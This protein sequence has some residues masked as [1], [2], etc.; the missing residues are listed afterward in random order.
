MFFE[1]VYRYDESRR[2]FD[3]R[4]LAPRMPATI[5]EIQTARDG[6]LEYIRQYP[7][8]SSIVPGSS[9]SLITPYDVQSP[10]ITVDRLVA[11]VNE[12]EAGNFRGLSWL[13]A[14]YRHWIRKDRLLRVDAITGERNGTGV[15][16]GYSPVGASKQQME[17]MAALT[18]GYRSGEYSGGSLPPG[19]DLKFKG[20]EGS[21]SEVYREPLSL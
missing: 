14:L 18:Q 2:G 12:Q 4:K 13:R 11:Y 6:G 8:G 16:I 17:Q 3:L 7:S 9:R 1:Q 5:S 19:W 10:K 21:R 20:V 15:P